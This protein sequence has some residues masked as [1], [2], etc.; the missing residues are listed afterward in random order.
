MEVR[1]EKEEQVIEP[2]LLINRS[3]C[4]PQQTW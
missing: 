2:K 4:S 3:L 1:N